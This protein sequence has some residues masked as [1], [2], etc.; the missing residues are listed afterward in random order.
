MNRS[1][2]DAGAAAFGGSGSGVKEEAEPAGHVHP[3]HPRGSLRGC[4]IAEAPVALTTTSAQ[5]RTTLGCPASTS[6][7]TVTL[8]RRPALTPP[9]GSR[10][11]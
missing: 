4:G 5:A 6:S 8:S 11:S 9:A 2:V 7:R 3:S 1:A 10:L